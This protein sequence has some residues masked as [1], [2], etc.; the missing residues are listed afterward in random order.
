MVALAAFVLYSFAQR[1][2]VLTASPFPIGVDGYFYSIQL[3]SLLETGALQYPA[4]PFAFWLL[5]PFAAATDPITG[6]KLGTACFGALIALPAYGIGVRLGNGRGP[7]LVAAA[8]ATFSAG[9]MYLTIEFV[10]NG[11]G[12][13]VALTALWLVLRALETSSRPRIALAIAGIVAALL[14]HKMAGGLTLALA[15]PAVL[16]EEIARGKLRG[17]RLLTLAIAGGVALVAIVVVGMLAPRRFLSPNDAR[18][19]HELF[20][21]DPDFTLPVAATS[22]GVLHLGYEPLVGAILGVLAAAA[23]IADRKFPATE[24]RLALRIRVVSWS[25]VVLAIAIGWPF[26]TVDDSQGLGMRLRIIAFVPMALCAAIA[27]RS[28][29]RFALPL[30]ATD[31]NPA[32]AIVCTLLVGVCMLRVPGFR[33]E[34]RVVAEPGMV[35]A[36][37]ALAGRIPDGD[38]VV[39]PE[40]HIAYM[41]QWYAHVTIS[42]RPEHV[43]IERRWRVMPRAF[44]GRDSSLYDALIVIRTRRDLPPVVGLHP[45]DA[46]G[47]VLVP[48]VTW[49][50]LVTRLPVSDRE[51]FA[52]WPTI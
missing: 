34:G 5:A 51:W 47:L 43:P 33:T 25:V 19:L 28:A 7:G 46:N 37:Y 17:R 20:T 26:L 36:S 29:L 23:L 38:V 49:Q 2:D 13:T 18:L 39:V 41:L 9:S 6:A 45:R 35:T 31:L 44:I 8:L 10:K 15:L 24:E 14:T 50:Y 4:S 30:V 32:R 12:I 16:A 42:T 11:I 40:R 52:A 1:W 48:E 22:R 3:R 21:W 27:L